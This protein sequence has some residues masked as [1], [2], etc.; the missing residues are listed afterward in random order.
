MISYAHLKFK[1]EKMSLQSSPELLTYILC[2]FLLIP[3]ENG[4]LTKI[5]FVMYHK[6]KSLKLNLKKEKKKKES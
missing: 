2:K 3:C 4:R 6:I 1:A 5:T